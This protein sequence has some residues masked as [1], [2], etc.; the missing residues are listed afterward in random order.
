MV[1]R[2][3]AFL[4]ACE[5]D[6]AVRKPGNV[7]WA[8]PGH[9][10]SAPLFIGSAQAA[11]TPLFQ[12]GASLGQRVERAVEA[13]WAAASCNTNLGIVLL[14]APLAMAMERA[15]DPEV[16]APLPD[17]VEEVLAQLTA[18]DAQAV[19][20]AIARANPGGLGEVP[21]G[22]V[23]DAPAMGLRSAMALSAERDVIALQYRDGFQQVFAWAAEQA[24]LAADAIDRDPVAVVQRVFLSVLS[25]HLDSHIVR[26]HGAAVA[27]DVSAQARIW[28]IRLG[29]GEDINRSPEFIAWD[30]SLK[31][32]RIN[33]G[34]SA[35]LTVAIMMLLMWR[36]GIC[37]L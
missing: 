22:D 12:C 29:H 19:F 9:G 5:L 27:A 28:L 23:R 35:D 14:C 30:E 24:G 17:A 11:V 13:S 25:S 37:W 18:Q 1:Q 36:K 7:S 20:R 32:D 34:T 6:V 10:M 33:P 2:Q 8:S 21:E 26:K 3:S 31:H 16:K 15:D 4:R